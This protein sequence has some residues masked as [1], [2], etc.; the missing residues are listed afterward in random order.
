MDETALRMPRRAQSFWGVPDNA[1]LFA[2]KFVQTHPADRRPTSTNPYSNSYGMGES[3]IAQFDRTSSPTGFTLSSSQDEYQREQEAYEDL[4]MG[5]NGRRQEYVPTG[6][7]ISGADLLDGPRRSELRDYEPR[8]DPFL[9]QLRQQTPDIERTPSRVQF[10]GAQ[11]RTFD[12]SILGSDVFE[13]LSSF[14]RSIAGNGRTSVSM[15]RQNRRD[16]L[17]QMRPPTP[18]RREDAPE[19]Y[20]HRRNG[21]SAPSSPTGAPTLRNIPDFKKGRSA[22]ELARLSGA[23]GENLAEYCSL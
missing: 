23:E 21:A 14:E 3:T 10:A 4:E 6:R 2:E 13:D 15:E 16:Q 8:G 18:P 12:S 5:Q 9:A 17:N 20:S 11:V 1:Q 22:A 19:F 7:P